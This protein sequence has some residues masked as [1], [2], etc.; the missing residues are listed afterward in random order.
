MKWHHSNNNDNNRQVLIVFKYNWQVL[1][2][3]TLLIILMYFKIES[4]DC[5][6]IIIEANLNLLRFKKKKCVTKFYLFTF[7]SVIET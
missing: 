1:N 2:C 5:I 4:F 7:P 6:Y 3:I